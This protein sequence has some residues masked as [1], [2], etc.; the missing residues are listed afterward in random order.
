MRTQSIMQQMA[1]V[2]GSDGGKSRVFWVAWENLASPTS[3]SAG[4]AN[5][6]P[7]PPFSDGR[8]EG[9]YPKDDNC[10]SFSLT[11]ATK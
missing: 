7:A 5:P 2:C 8:T 11:Q 9:R 4:A 1:L 3:S 10:D 6:A